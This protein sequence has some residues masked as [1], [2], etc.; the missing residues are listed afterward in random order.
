MLVMIIMQENLSMNIYDEYTSWLHHAAH[1]MFQVDVWLV[2]YNRSKG[3]HICIAATAQ[4]L[5]NPGLIHLTHSPQQIKLI[6]ETKKRE[7]QTEN[8]HYL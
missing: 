2:F 3:R 7:N 6:N 1:T 8:R 4:V 5:N